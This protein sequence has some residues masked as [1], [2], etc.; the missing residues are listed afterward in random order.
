M[1]IVIRVSISS[2][3]EAETSGFE[4]GDHGAASQGREENIFRAPRAPTTTPLGVQAPEGACV[5]E[6]SDEQHARGSRE[7]PESA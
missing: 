4:T 7:G 2:P 5:E 3:W 6:E 1:V